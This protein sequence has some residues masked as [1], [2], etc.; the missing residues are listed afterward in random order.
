MSYEIEKGVPVPEQTGRGRSL[1]Y[2]FPDMEIGDSILTETRS[3][4][5][6]ASNWASRQKN[7]WKFI[8]KKVEGG[9]RIWR[10]K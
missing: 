8:S 9:F 6:A 7:G 10:T 1:K 2:P 3:A 5:H 4:F